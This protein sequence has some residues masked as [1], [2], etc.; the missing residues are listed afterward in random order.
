MDKTTFAVLVFVLTSAADVGLCDPPDQRTE[1]STSIEL[2]FEIGPAN[3]LP[4][5]E[6]T[7]ASQTVRL[8]VDTGASYSVLDH[9][10]E[11]YRGVLKRSTSLNGRT[12]ELFEGPEISTGGSKVKMHEVAC[13]SLRSVHRKF[14]REIHGIVG[15]DT[16]MHYAVEFDFDR[17]VIVL[18]SKGYEPNWSD[19]VCDV[20]YGTAQRPTIKASFNSSKAWV[21]VDTGNSGNG[22]LAHQIFDADKLAGSI[23][24]I[25]SVNFA[26]IADS[27][28]RTLR[29]LV[30]RVSVG[31][32]SHGS[33]AFSRY[34][35]C[36]FGLNYLKR[37]R[38]LLDVSENRC[39]LATAKRHHW[40][41]MSDMGGITLSGDGVTVAAIRFGSTADAA[42][43]K[44]GDK[45]RE[46]GNQVVTDA[47][48]LL[49]QLREKPF[50]V[51][52]ER[53]G[54][55]RRVQMRLYRE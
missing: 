37:Y 27:D 8:V 19:Y 38:M 35:Y 20:R 12:V 41:D 29:G 17:E 28:G 22:T 7:I 14:D 11:A 16:L 34:A 40:K 55:A 49:S 18:H 39:F 6:A 53:D 33:L 31:D 2:K 48:Y 15:M 5:V 13:I 36:S 3:P 45:I 1:A 21:L 47:T 51:T 52:I 26:T 32:Y 9:S 43:L 42:G 54:L 44:P 23:S 10:L 30:K 46:V 24:L 25:G 4:V 50:G